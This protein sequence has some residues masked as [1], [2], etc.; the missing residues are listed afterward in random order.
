MIIFRIGNRADAE[1]ALRLL[2]TYLAEEPAAP[3]P[4]EAAPP[5]EPGDMPL[6]A[7]TLTPTTVGKLVRHGIVTVEQLLAHRL[8]DLERLPHIRRA[9]VV[10]VLL[11]L[12]QRGL[13]LK[14]ITA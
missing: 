8:A 12:R 6:A 4:L 9:N 7:L 11:A 5:P 2:H 13:Q 3:E 14:G 1:R 10:E